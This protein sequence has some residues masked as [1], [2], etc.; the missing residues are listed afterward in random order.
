MLYT[1]R[2]LLAGFGLASLPVWIPSWIKKAETFLP[3]ETSALEK[4]ACPFRLAVINDEITQD[5][6]KA[7]RIVANDFGLRWIELRSMWDKNVTELSAQQI[8]DAKKILSEHKLQVTDIASPLFKTDW[9]GAPRS[10]PSETRDQF[11]ANFDANAQD[12]F[13]K[14]VFRLP[15]HSRRK[16][17]A[18]SITGGW[19][20]RNPIVRRSTLNSKGRRTMCQRHLVLLLENEMSCNTATV[21][22][23]PP[24][25]G[26]IP[27]RN[28]M[29]NWDPGNAAAPAMTSY[30]VGL[31]PYPKIASA[32]V[33]AKTSCANP[34]TN[35][36]GRPVGGGMVNWTG[37]LR[38][39]ND[40][41]FRYGLSLETH[42]RGAGT[43]EAIHANQHGWA[44]G[45]IDQSRTFIAESHTAGIY[46]A[47]RCPREEEKMRHAT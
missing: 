16:G 33:I 41:G 25:S 47:P 2:K 11:H 36:I 15:M 8:E 4:G 5:F 34:T 24:S 45:G 1:R 44:Q 21:L 46:G 19:M 37:Q 29:L 38:A 31:Q 40:D 3:K 6:E 35:T 30:R 17:F 43:P 12:H 10:P 18:V 7:C 42:W 13:S 26:R 27:N 9:P 32:I 28:F 39:L 22:K 14:T 23:R 20:I